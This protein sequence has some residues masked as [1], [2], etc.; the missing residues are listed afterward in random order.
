MGNTLSL[1][2]SLIQS[3]A[4]P[5]PATQTMREMTATRSSQVASVNFK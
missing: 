3:G 2:I 1:I 4:R 5:N